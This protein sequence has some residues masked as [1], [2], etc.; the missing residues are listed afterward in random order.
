MQGKAWSCVSRGSYAGFTIFTYVCI[1]WYGRQLITIISHLVPSK[2]HI[3]NI[4]A[5]SLICDASSSIIVCLSV[6]FGLSC[7]FPP[8]TEAKG[9][10]H[11][12]NRSYALGVVAVWRRKIQFLDNVGTYSTNTEDYV[13]Q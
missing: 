12:S 4:G 8:L 11:S 13:K 6:C 3:S 10:R 7:F 2:K 5:C 9:R 1:S